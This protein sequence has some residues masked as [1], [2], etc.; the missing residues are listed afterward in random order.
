[1]ATWQV[2]CQGHMNCSLVNCGKERLGNLW[3]KIHFLIVVTEV[4]GPGFLRRMLK[5]RFDIHHRYTLG[6]KYCISP[7]LSPS[8]ATNKVPLLH[9]LLCSQRVSYRPISAELH[10]VCHHL[11]R[12]TW[13]LR[14]WAPAW[15][16]F[17][18]DHPR[19]CPTPTMLQKN[20]YNWF[21][22]TKCTHW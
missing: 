9:T 22:I 5:Q 16:C 14:Q 15:A 6:K 13:P 17:T 4:P 18:P 1:M 11:Q 3:V 21:K 7:F 2:P 19:L 12:N 10:A 8:S 20:S